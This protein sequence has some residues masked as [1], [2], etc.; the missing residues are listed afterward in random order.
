[1]IYRHYNFKVGK[2]HSLCKGN[3]K[4]EVPPVTLC[5]QNILGVFLLFLPIEETH[6]ISVTDPTSLFMRCVFL[7]GAILKEAHPLSL[8]DRV[9]SLLKHF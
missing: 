4:I 5:F 8:E 6:S 1:M 9:Q 7:R 3:V 2:I